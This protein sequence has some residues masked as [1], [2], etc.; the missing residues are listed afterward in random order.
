MGEV[1]MQV[2]NPPAGQKPLHQ[3][4]GLKQMFEGG[5]F[6][7]SPETAQGRA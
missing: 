6:A 3:I 1:G 4:A 5:R 2:A 7:G